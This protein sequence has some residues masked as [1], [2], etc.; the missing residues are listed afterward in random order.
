MYGHSKNLCL[1]LTPQKNATR[2]TIFYALT[3]TLIKI[4]IL[5][6]YREIFVGKRFVL[7]TYIIGAYVLAWF[8]EYE[9]VA[10][11]NCKNFKVAWDVAANSPTECIYIRAVTI[12]ETLSNIVADVAILCLPL[13]EVWKL[14]MSLKLKVAVAGIFLLGGL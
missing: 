4:S 10:N 1:V 14:Q 8:L 7:L 3:Q 6:F 11:L 5:L 9:L 13:G 12:G 2:I